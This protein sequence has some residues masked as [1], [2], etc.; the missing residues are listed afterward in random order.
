MDTRPKMKL[1]LSPLDNKLELTGKI[2]LVFM[3]ALT[4]YIFLKLPTTI[5]T[6]FNAWGQADD[7]GNKLTLLIL[8]ILSTIIYFGLTQLNKYPHIFNYMTEITED[9]ALKQYA[10]ATRMFRFLKLA[11]LVIFS[12]IILFTYLTTIGVTNGLGFWFIPLTSAI[13]LIPTIISIRQ[14]FRK[15]NNVA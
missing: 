8:P 7:Y 10:I 2:F 15:N 13:L 3:W 9:N 11:I 4:L 6:L 12:F 14:S 5:P 1:N